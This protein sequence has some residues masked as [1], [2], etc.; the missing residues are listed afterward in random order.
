MLNGGNVIGAVI[1]Y[2]QWVDFDAEFVSINDALCIYALGPSYRFAGA[3]GS[4][5]DGFYLKDITVAE[6]PFF[7]LSPAYFYDPESLIGR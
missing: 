6:V 2:N 3:A 5:F 4:R 7:R 1:T